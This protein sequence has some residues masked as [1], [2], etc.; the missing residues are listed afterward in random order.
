MG[1][2]FATKDVA[3]GGG[4]WLGSGRLDFSYCPPPRPTG[5]MGLLGLQVGSQTHHAPVPARE[6]D[7]LSPQVLSG[8][9]V[10]SETDTGKEDNKI[11]FHHKRQFLKCFGGRRGWIEI[12]ICP[13]NR[14]VNG[15]T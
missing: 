6:G 10:Q 5:R 11:G 3:A 15:R 2:G 8:P 7:W 9:R 12:C 1:R 14:R 4:V 13:H